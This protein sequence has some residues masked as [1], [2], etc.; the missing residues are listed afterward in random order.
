M[1]Y[2]GMPRRYFDYL[3]EFETLQFISTVGSWIVAF[4]ILMVLHN[5]FRSIRKGEKATANPWGGVT[6]EWQT[7]SPPP[8]ENFEIDPVV[9]TEAYD[10]TQLKELEDDRQ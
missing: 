1:G 3:P 5:L 4:A 7:S 9:E 10:F 2:M 8:L 6:L